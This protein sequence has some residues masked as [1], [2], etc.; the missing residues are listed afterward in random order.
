MTKTRLLWP[1]FVG[2]LFGTLV[3][4]LGFFAKSALGRWCFKLFP[5]NGLFLLSFIV[6]AI[7]SLIILTL[8]HIPKKWQIRLTF[9]LLLGGLGI[10]FDYFSLQYSF[11][12]EKLPYLLK[13]GLLNTLWVSALSIVIAC[14]IGFIAAI[15][16]LSTHGFWVGLSTFYISFF[17][18]TPLLL[19]VFL[20]YQGLP[21]I[22]II[23][24]AGLAGVIALSMGYGAYMAE[25]FRAGIEG[26]AR[27]QREAAIALGLSR[28][29]TLC[30]IILPQALRLT[31]PPI[32]NQFLSML[33]DS[34]LVSIMGIWELMFLARTQGR[35]EFKHLEML[36][37]AA[38]IYW[39]VSLVL[40]IGQNWLER[41]FKS[42]LSKL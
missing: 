20:I 26:V 25:I 10:F 38:I 12:A 33:K 28:G 32:G 39:V 6:L 41:R 9:I 31:I 30:R 5:E 24:D 35:A 37:T 19:Q 2:F 21:Q 14:F 22:G 40:E 4:A 42:N 15:A 23:L 1:V 16:R 34:S 36:I 17:R 3:Y 29:Q 27:G 7:V 13:V 8:N 11:I 18:G